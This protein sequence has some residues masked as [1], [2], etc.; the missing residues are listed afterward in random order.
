MQRLR[1]SFLLC[2]LVILLCAGCS[3]AP[4]GVERKVVTGTVIFD[5]KPLEYGTISFFPATPGGK[6]T[7][8]SATVTNGSYR[9]PTENGLAPGSYKVSITAPKNRPA[10]LPSD[11]D[12]AMKAAATAAP[13][14]ELIPAQYNTKT[15][16]TCTVE[17]SGETKADFEL[18]ASKS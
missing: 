18:K 15:N 7:A 4:E 13:A 2:G 5:G 1:R 8:T 16:L 3:R 12:A 17:Q 11:P 6:E 14:I 9:L 10:D